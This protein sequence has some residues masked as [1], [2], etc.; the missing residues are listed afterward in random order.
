VQKRFRN[1]LVI[2]AGAA[3]LLAGV[4]FLGRGIPETGA[5]VM[6]LVANRDLLAGTTLDDWSLLNVERRPLHE[7]LD[8]YSPVDVLR[9]CIVTRKILDG[10]VVLNDDL[11][12]RHE[13]AA[14][15]LGK[16][17]EIPLDQVLHDEVRFPPTV[18]HRPRKS[19]S[20]VVIANRDLLRGTVLTEP[21][22]QPFRAHNMEEAGLA[23]YSP[24][25]IINRFVGKG[26]ILLA[27]CILREVEGVW[28][29]RRLW[30]VPIRTMGDRGALRKPMFV[31]IYWHLKDEKREICTSIK[32]KVWSASGLESSVILDMLPSEA[33][34]ILLPSKTGVGGSIYLVKSKDRGDILNL[35]PFEVDSILLS[36]KRARAIQQLLSEALAEVRV[37]RLR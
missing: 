17:E 14:K 12:W 15:H 28:F 35:L 36:S 13:P 20:F 1:T 29:K 6:V 24:F 19:A 27:N 34:S 4:L 11:L 16:E 18:W 9:D 8:A 30:I 7:A 32:S 2:C 26:Q 33:D 3:L 5:E 23:T 25:P 10:Q 31:D 21:R 22:V 37:P